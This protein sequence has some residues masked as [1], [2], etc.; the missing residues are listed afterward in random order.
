VGGESLP[1][2]AFLLGGPD[3]RKWQ[4]PLN[5]KTNI[6][7][8]IAGFGRL[9]ISDEDKS[10]AWRALKAAAESNGI[11]IDAAQRKQPVRKGMY[12]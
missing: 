4:F 9:A 8:A 2:S 3:P 5:T 11:D 7:K 6:R 10:H 1:A 12:R